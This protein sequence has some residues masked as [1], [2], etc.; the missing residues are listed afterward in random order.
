MELCS[1]FGPDDYKLSVK[2]DG[3]LIKAAGRRGLLYGCESLFQLITAGTIP[4]CDIDD[5]PYK[6]MR[7]FHFY[8][9]PKDQLEFAKKIFKY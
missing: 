2:P 1:C 6:E 4:V 3:I 8:L 9:P 7:G 5:K